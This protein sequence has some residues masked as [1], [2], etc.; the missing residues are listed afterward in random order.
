MTFNFKKQQM[1]RSLSPL[2]IVLLYAMPLSCVVEARQL[3]GSDPSTLVVI[4]GRAVC[5]DE[6]G[7]RIDALLGCN[8]Q[9][10]RF[11]FVDK[12]GKLYIFDPA[13]SSTAVFTDERVRARDLQVTAR[14]NA[15]KRLEL[16]KVQSIREGKLY[17]VYYF[18]EI[19]N[20]RAYA[21]GPCPCCRKELEFKETPP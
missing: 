11:G 15:N 5:L 17:D 4:R 12:E 6:S 9:S 2:L 20:I 10:G 14:L 1:I 19:C 7:N 13:D 21:P 8:E 18:C 3:K 16:I